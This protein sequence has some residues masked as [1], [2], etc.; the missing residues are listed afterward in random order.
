LGDG[1]YE[2]RDVGTGVRIFYTMLP[3]KRIVLLD[4]MTKKRDDLPAD[5]LQ[6]LRG[7][8]DT[9]KSRDAAARRVAQKPKIAGR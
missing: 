2:L 4:A 1:L 3:N 6:R 9:V 8:K 5:V 7:L